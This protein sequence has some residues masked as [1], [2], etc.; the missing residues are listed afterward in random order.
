MAQ[1]AVATTA[2]GP[3][4]GKSDPGAALS[5][6]HRSFVLFVVG[7][8]DYGTGRGG[9]VTVVAGSVVAESPTGA[10]TAVSVLV[11]ISIS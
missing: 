9:A 4:A 3:T 2:V 8:R 5:E 6:C 10:L 7:V 11:R 1:A